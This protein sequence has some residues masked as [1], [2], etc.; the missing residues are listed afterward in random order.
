MSS[1]LLLEKTNLSLIKSENLKKFFEEFEIEVVFD[2]K[3]DKELI[4]KDTLDMANEIPA[5]CEGCGSIIDIENFGHLV[6]G[7][8]L[9]Y[10]KNPLCFNHFLAT[11][12]IK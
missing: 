12:K 6:K 1:E 8:K 9:I 5:K 3:M 7:S 10:C 2:K 4:F 11:R